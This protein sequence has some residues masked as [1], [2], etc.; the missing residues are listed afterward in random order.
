MVLDRRLA[1]FI[2]SQPQV[3]I[4]LQCRKL[5]E[6]VLVSGDTE[7]PAVKLMSVGLFPVLL[8]FRPFDVMFPEVVGLVTHGG[9]TSSWKPRAAPFT[10]FAWWSRFSRSPMVAW[11]ANSIKA[12]RPLNPFKETVDIPLKL[13]CSKAKTEAEQ[14]YHTT[15]AYCID[16]CMHLYLCSVHMNTQSQ[17]YSLVKCVL[18]VTY[19]VLHTN[20]ELLANKSSEPIFS[21]L[22]KCFNKR[23]LQFSTK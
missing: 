16:I 10:R 6:T 21:P 8:D 17:V 2:L 3:C 23:I 4:C 11:I 22:K 15:G 5:Q 12:A 19:Q 9:V 20:Q 13:M 7:Q 14:Q 1:C 18:L